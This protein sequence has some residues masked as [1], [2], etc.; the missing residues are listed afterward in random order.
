MRAIV[1]IGQRGTGKTTLGA[2]LADRLGLPFWDSDQVF[3]R[4]LGCSP[5]DWIRNLGEAS[6][7]QQEERV[8]CRLLRRILLVPGVL[9]LGG[10][11]PCSSLTRGWM[12]RLRQGTG[13]VVYL[14]CSLE[15]ALE[16]QRGRAEQEPLLRAASPRE[17]GARLF[18]QRHSIYLQASDLL[19]EN[20]FASPGTA[21]EAL[22]SLLGLEV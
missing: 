14:T 7:R 5:G 8:V 21:L 6:F 16:R 19:F 15:R 2:L 20:D 3:H 12:G 17:D 11:A 4:E 22:V 13:W 1:L 10:G 18:A 9:A